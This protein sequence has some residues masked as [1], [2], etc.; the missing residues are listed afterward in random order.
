MLGYFLSTY[1]KPKTPLNESGDL[2]VIFAGLPRCATSTLKQ[3][4]ETDLYRQ[5]CAHFQYFLG[6]TVQIRM[7]RQCAIEDDAAKRQKLLRSLLAGSVGTADIPGCLFV[8]DLIDMYPDAKVV[9]NLR[10]GGAEQWYKSTKI[11]QMGLDPFD[12]WVI[13]LNPQLYHRYRAEHEWRRVFQKRFG[14]KPSEP[15]RIW[16]KEWYGM[17]AQWVRDVCAAKG[18]PLLEW[19]PSDGYGPLCKFLEIPAPDKPMPHLNDGAGLNKKY[20]MMVVFGAMHWVALLGCCAVLYMAAKCV[21]VRDMLRI[22]TA[23]ALL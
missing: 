18:R 5:K 6:N 11:L 19:K 8:D 16:Q 10:D 7:S 14:V 22:N 17:H 9:L 4:I 3:A 23:F 12:F 20:W 13:C 21:F 15:G 1:G 2:K